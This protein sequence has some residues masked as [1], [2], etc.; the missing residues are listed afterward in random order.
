MFTC[1]LQ[2]FYAIFYFYFYIDNHNIAKVK[3]NLLTPMSSSTLN[4]YSTLFCAKLEE[5]ANTSSV[6]C[7][8]IILLTENLKKLL[9]VYSK[10]IPC[11]YLMIFIF[12]R[13]FKTFITTWLQ[14]FCGKTTRLLYLLLFSS[15]SQRDM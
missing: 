15:W 1:K 14:E 4:L 2:Y 6:W 3:T 11:I 10:N 5:C 7:I 12:Q 13:I 9:K 8:C